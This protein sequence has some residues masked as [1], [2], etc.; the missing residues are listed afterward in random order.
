MIEGIRARHAACCSRFLAS[1]EGLGVLER[2]QKW[3]G[4]NHLFPTTRGSDTGHKGLMPGVNATRPFVPPD[5]GGAVT[6]TMQA[7]R[8]SLKMDNE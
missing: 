5:S 4:Q 7:W 2:V 3:V 1:W 6:V 8:L